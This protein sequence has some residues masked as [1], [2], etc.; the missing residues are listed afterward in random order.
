MNHTKLLFLDSA[1][2]V[3]VERAAASRIVSGITTNPSIMGRPRDQH[4]QHLRL[5]LDTFTAGPVFYQLTVLDES[6]ARTEVDAVIAIAGEHRD[7]V[8]FKL[9]AQE[10]LYPVSAE[11]VSR[12][13]GVAFT[14]VYSAGQAISAAAAG[15]SWLIPYVDRASRLAPDEPPVVSQLVSVI[16]PDVKVL[17]ASIKSAPQAIEAMVLGATGV[18]APWPVLSSLMSHPLTDSAVDEFQTALASF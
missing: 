1:D 5:M 7:R 18:T 11:L 12:G 15:A 9:P 16:P 4:P 13:F 10:W 3:Q 8:V 17:A 2:L 14:A 6:A